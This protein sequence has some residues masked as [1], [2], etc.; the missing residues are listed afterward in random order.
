MSFGPFMDGISVDDG[1]TNVIIT[2]RNIVKVASVIVKV[3]LDFST[4][5]PLDEHCSDVNNLI[6]VL[7]HVFYHGLRISKLRKFSHPWRYI[8]NVGCDYLDCIKSV[9]LLNYLKNDYSKL[10]AWIKIA[11]VRHCIH[12]TVS[13]IQKTAAGTIE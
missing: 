9:R 3:I 10:R 4:K 2:K 6:T 13:L 1:A 12:Y 8:T 5:R 7:E 11:L